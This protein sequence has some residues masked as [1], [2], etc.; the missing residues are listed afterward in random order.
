MYSSIIMESNLNISGSVFYSPHTNIV[1]SSKHILCLR[2]KIVMLAG[3]L[4]RAKVLANLG[5]VQYSIV[6]LTYMRMHVRSVDG[7]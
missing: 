5:T 3:N 1:E 2:N 4:V 7:F 6:T